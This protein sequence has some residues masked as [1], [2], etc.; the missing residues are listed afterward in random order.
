MVEKKML[1]S[2]HLNI[3]AFTNISVNSDLCYELYRHVIRVKMVVE[4]QMKLS[5][6][7]NLYATMINQNKIVI[8][9]FPIRYVGVRL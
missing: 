9:A 5:K 1:P 2:V 3:F 6:V 7:K 4:K 8:V